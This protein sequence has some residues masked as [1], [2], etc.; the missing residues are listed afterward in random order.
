[1]AA[2]LGKSGEV[3]LDW[4]K[5]GAVLAAPAPNEKGA[6]VVVAGVVVAAP[7]AKGLGVAAVAPAVPNAKGALAVVAATVVVGAPKANACDT[8]GM[9]CFEAGAPNV[10][11]VPESND[12]DVVADESGA[13]AVAC[14]CCCWGVC[15]PNL[16]N[17]PLPAEESAM[18]P[19]PNE[20]PPFGAGVLVADTPLPNAKPPLIGCVA[21]AVDGPVGDCTAVEP[22]AGGDAIAVGFC[23]AALPP[24]ANMLELCVACVVVW[25][26]GAAAP[27]LNGPDDG[28]PAALA[29]GAAGPAPFEPNLNGSVDDVVTEGK[30]PCDAA[31]FA[32]CVVEPNCKSVDPAKL[33]WAVLLT[34]ALVSLALSTG[35]AGDAATVPKVGTGEAG[36]AFRLPPSDG[37]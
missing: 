29:A 13:A 17:V 21:R 31:G 32:A 22:N 18:F 6:G 16:N 35:N 34:A 19:A 12:A 2:A 24:K 9:P 14:C 26:L 15:A 30:N 11:G 10:N 3:T 20:K 37:P 28:G 33:D 7:K 23:T 4:G 1:M 27:N 25:E 5:A 36:G 8:V